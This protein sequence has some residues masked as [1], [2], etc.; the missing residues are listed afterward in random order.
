M[1][2]KGLIKSCGTIKDHTN[3]RKR[4]LVELRTKKNK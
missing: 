2:I 1:L 4:T 3:G